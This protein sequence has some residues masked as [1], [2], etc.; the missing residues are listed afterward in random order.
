VALLLAVSLRAFSQ[1]LPAANN[2]AYSTAANTPLAVAASSGVLAYDFDPNGLRITASLDIAPSNGTI[3]LNADG[4]FTYTP[5]NGFLGYDYFTYSV[6]DTN[7]TSAPATVTLDVGNERWDDQFSPSRFGQEV[8]AISVATNGDFYV[9]GFMSGGISRWDGRIWSKLGNRLLNAVKGSIDALA[10]QNGFL[11]VGGSFSKA[12][13]R[14]AENLAQWNGTEWSAFSGG[15]D[16]PVQALCVANNLLYVGGQ[17]T[18]AGNQRVSNMTLWDGTN[19]SNLNGGV[20]GPVASI[21][22]DTNGDIYLAGAFTK[23]GGIVA[24][25]IAE[26]S[27]GSWVSLGSGV[28]GSIKSLLIQDGQLYAGGS[29]TNIGGITATNIA[30]WDGTNWSALGNGAFGGPVDSLAVHNGQLYAGQSAPP[31]S[32]S[33]AQVLQWNG[34]NWAP[35]RKCSIPRAPQ[36]SS[37]SFS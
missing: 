34:T 3:E 29:F 8:T 37:H 21:V 24:H 17:F 13:G 11:I 14:P 20:D 25:G 23:A 28:S 9:A 27:D 10:W 6:S 26:W 12:G 19:W 4:S 35:S 36:A 31:G 32:F 7:G 16:G 5:N 18:N 2:V 15:F 30:R 1:V 22:A 33:P